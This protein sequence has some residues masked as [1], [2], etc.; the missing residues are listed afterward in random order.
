MFTAS[1]HFY[2]KNKSK[3]IG[4][5]FNDQRTLYGNYDEVLNLSLKLRI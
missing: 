5:I 1:Q 4:H 3:E 2:I